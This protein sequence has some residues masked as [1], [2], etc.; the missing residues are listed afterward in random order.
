[1]V[2]EPLFHS[3]DVHGYES[4]DCKTNCQSSFEKHDFLLSLF[5]PKRLR[6]RNYAAIFNKRFNFIRTNRVNELT[7]DL[8]Q[9]TEG[10]F[11]DAVRASPLALIKIFECAAVFTFHGVIPTLIVF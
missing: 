5:R 3:L 10:R 9:L 4:Q 8:L 2:G 1:M 6:H 11:I 7:E